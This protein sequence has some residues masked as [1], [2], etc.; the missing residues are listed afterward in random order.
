MQLEPVA[1]AGEGFYYREEDRPG[2][3]PLHEAGM[4]YI[5]EPSAMAV[6]Q[7][8]DP[9]AGR[10][11]GFMCGARRKNDASCL[12]LKGK[13]FLLSNEI[14]PAR[15]RILSQNVE[16]MGIW[17]CAVT[18]QSPGGAV[19]PFPG[20]F[21]RGSLWMPPAPVRECSARSRRQ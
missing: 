16:R 7:L 14:H 17:N 1:W 5:Q 18:N 2:R 13:G 20:I 11:D 4:Y 6:V 21:S 10:A 12:R 3:H 8:L 15:A 19:R 9:S